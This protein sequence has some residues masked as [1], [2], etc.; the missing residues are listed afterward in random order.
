MH[1]SLRES[2]GETL[3]MALRNVRRVLALVNQVLALA[4]T[5]SGAMRLQARPG[6]V[7]AL[8]REQSVAFYAFTGRRRITFTAET[9]D[10]PGV[11]P[12]S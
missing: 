5:E 9:P 6:D 2:A 4:K 10:D 11:P 7:G 8:V 1:G 12:S 3:E